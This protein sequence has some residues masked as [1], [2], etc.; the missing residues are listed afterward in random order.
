[1]DSKYL[2][3]LATSKICRNIF[4]ET[5]RR[6]YVTNFSN[7]VQICQKFIANISN[8]LQIH[9]KKINDM[10]LSEGSE[11]VRNPSLKISAM[12]FGLLATEFSIASSLFFC[13][14][15]YAQQQT[16]DNQE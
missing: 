10:T 9:Q 13:S 2:M 4:D 16:L 14:E 11:S 3:N 1:M 15:I 7:R 5:I 12:D 8:G 6:K